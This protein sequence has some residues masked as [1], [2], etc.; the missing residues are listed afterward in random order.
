MSHA[1]HGPRALDAEG[2]AALVDALVAAGYRVLGPAVKGG[3]IVYD[4][5]ASGK[6]LPRGFTEDQ[7]AGR[8][9]LGRRDDE[10]FFGF[11]VGPTS[12]KRFLHPPDLLRF[13]ASREG[14]GFAVEPADGAPTSLALLGVR[15]C[16]LAAIAR[17]DRVLLGGPYA[18]PA[19]AARRTE[20]FVVAVQCTE[21]GG[22][23][24]CASMGTGP[25]AESG[26]DLALTEGPASAFVVEVG[27][28]RGAEL[29]GRV[30][31]RPAAADEVAAARAATDAA[32][33]KMGRTLETAGLKEA[34]QAAAESPRWEAVAGRC[35]SC[36]NCTLACPT[37]FCTT[38]EDTTD[39][40]GGRAERWR[41]WDSCFS[42]D[43]S[44]IHGGSVRRTPSSRYRQ[45]LTHKLASWHDQF[46]EPGCVGCGRCI[47][48]CPAGIDLTEEARA[49][50]RGPVPA[51]AARKE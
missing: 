19:Y 2:L 29:L 28:S 20:A 13:R 18:D 35:L 31:N 15:P 14:H 1:P 5:V 39:V 48:W 24:F 36:A 47:T 23:C 44:Y 8:Y 41:R 34:L 22:T 50:A 9:R 26:F 27:S 32:R 30:P 38:V 17:Q 49:V 7:D 3:A 11:A 33:G 16:D 10:A 46:G 12:W 43:F 45:W 40:T 6:E 4:E 21:P 37:C 42:L 51:K 25:R